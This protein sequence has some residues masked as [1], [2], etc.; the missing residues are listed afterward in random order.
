MKAVVL[1]ALTSLAAVIITGCFPQPSARNNPF[2]PGAGN[3]SGGD[4]PPTLVLSLDTNASYEEHMFQFDLRGSSDDFTDN[5]QLQVQIDWQNDGMWDVAWTNGL[6]HT[7]SFSTPAAYT[8]RIQM[9]DS[10]TNI[11]TKNVSVTV[12]ALPAQYGD[13]SDSNIT[14]VSGNT[15]SVD[16]IYNLDSVIGV[17]TYRG[18]NKGLN[19]GAGTYQ[20]KT[21]VFIQAKTFIVESGATLTAKKHK[22]DGGA[23]NEAYG[24]V[25]IA[26]RAMFSNAGLLDLNGKGFNGGSMRF[27]GGFFATGPGNG[28]SGTP[29]PTGD[30]MNT[31]GGTAGASCGSTGIPCTNAAW[32]AIFG[33][34]GGGGGNFYDGSDGARGGD[35]G[36]AVRIYAV[37]FDTA[38]GLIQCGGL[39][40]AKGVSYDNSG[41]I[42]TGCGGGGAGGTIYIESMNARLG[43]SKMSCA[44]GIGSNYGDPIIQSDYTTGCGG[45]AGG[46]NRSAGGAGYAGGKLGDSTGPG[47]K[48]GNGS[49]GRIHVVGTYTGST[50]APPIE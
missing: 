40:G 47:S 16:D 45:G 8:V 17:I 1:F 20:P 41:Y 13:G 32:D 21:G 26:A 23:T 46:G 48:G 22:T 9:R 18:T 35:G 2:D 5:S 29:Q 42:A 19:H 49:L 38:T 37:A 44:G 31:A 28:G 34:G 12:S 24:I 3:Y 39:D 33:S 6:V 4:K 43:T 30:H 27:S 10:R 50:G 11:A 25:W 7:H 14:V 15:V 36:G